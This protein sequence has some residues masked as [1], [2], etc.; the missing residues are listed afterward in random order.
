MQ[1]VYFSYY[2]YKDWH[3][4]L[5]TTNK[6]LCYIGFEDETIDGLKKSCIQQ[7]QDCTCIENQEILLPVIQQLNDYF[8]GSL[9]NFTL[10]L[11]IHG[12]DFQMKVWQALQKVEYG[13]TVPYSTIAA[14]IGNPKAVRAV[15]TAIGKNPVPIVVPCHRVISKDGSIGGFSGGLHNK[16]KLLAIE[17]IE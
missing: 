17:S 2:Q 13:K 1:T 7:F 6:G 3:L 12:T 4:L 9:T 16:E 10:P 14:L 5:G 11:H 8:D 15:G